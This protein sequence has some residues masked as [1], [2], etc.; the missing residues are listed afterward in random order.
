M[1][2][3][4]DK[5]PLGPAARA[6]VTMQIE[7]LPPLDLSPGDIAAWRKLQAGN[8]DHVSPYLTPDWARAVA[9]HRPDAR[10]I[11]F[12]EQ[13]RAI[14]FLPLQMSAAGIAQPIGGPVCDYQAVIGPNTARFDLAA[15]ARTMGAKRIDIS[16]GIKNSP[17]GCRLKTEEHGYVTRF[18]DGFDAWCEERRNAGTKIVQRTQKSRRKL[19]REKGKLS[20]ESFSRDE[21]AFDLLIEWKRDQMRRTGVADVYERPWISGLVHETFAMQPTRA[22]G[23]ALF[24]LKLNNAPIAALYCLQAG[25]CLHAWITAYDEGY[26]DYS[27]GMIVF[28]DAIRAAAGAGFSEMDFGP[29][30]QRYKDSFA[31][32]LRP[33]GAGF[34]GASGIATLHRAAEFRFRNVVERLP[35]G[36][37]R[38]WPGKAMRRLDIAAGLIPPADHH[39]SA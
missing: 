34:A 13:G 33:V 4:A 5:R 19:E 12:R 11:V 38:H 7:S 36:R 10:V 30:P 23:G 20:F 26:S 18:P 17:L 2:L 21:T 1:H 32:Y 37:A 27:P 22:F 16:Y 25:P 6:G 15:A 14:G 28:L 9:R 24:V 29:G 31:N 3:D 39:L 8:V 35:V